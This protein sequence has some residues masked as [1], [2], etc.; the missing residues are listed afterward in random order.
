MIQLF[1][2]L[3]PKRLLEAGKAAGFV[4][5]MSEAEGEKRPSGPDGQ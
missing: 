3:D 2:L 1:G 4:R 5:G